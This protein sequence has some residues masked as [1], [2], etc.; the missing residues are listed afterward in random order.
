MT[1]FPRFNLTPGQI[2]LI[3]DAE[4]KVDERRGTTIWFKECF[5]SGVKGYTDAELARLFHKGTIVIKPEA[6]QTMTANEALN[7]QLMAVDALEPKFQEGLKRKH[8]Y[9]LAGLGAEGG[10][11]ASLAAI[12]RATAH[13]LGDS[14]PPRPGTVRVWKR[15]LVR[16]GMDPRALLGARAY[17]N[18]RQR[19]LHHLVHR[20]MRKVIGRFYLSRNRLSIEAV[21]GIL[22]R[23]MENLRKRYPELDFTMPSIATLAREIRRI[24]PYIVK[25]AREGTRAADRQF[26]IKKLG[27]RATRPLELVIIDSKIMDIFWTDREGRV[28]ERLTLTVV[29]DV[30]SRMILGFYLGPGKPS[31]LTNMQAMRN[32]FAP[33]DYVGHL[34]PEI[35]TE[36]PCYG[37]PDALSLDQGTEN[38]NTHLPFVLGTFGIDT[39]FGPGGKPENRGIIEAW[40]DT[41]NALIHNIA[42]TTRSNPKDRGDADRERETAVEEAREAGITLEDLRALVHRWILDVYHNREHAELRMS[43]LQKWTEGVSKHALRPPPPEEQ[44][45]ILLGKTKVCRLQHY[46]I[47]LFGLIY[48]A[49]ELA[50]LR[51]RKGASRTVTV[52]WDPSNISCIW[53]KD[54]ATHRWIKA[55]ADDQIY[56]RNLSEAQHKMAWRAARAKYAK[57]R[58]SEDELRAI[59]AEIIETYLKARPRKNKI[60]RGTPMDAHPNMPFGT[61]ADASTDGTPA[62]PRPL[63]EPDGLLNG[64]ETSWDDDITAA[65]LADLRRANGDLPEARTPEAKELGE[66]FDPDEDEDLGLEEEGAPGA[67]AGKVRSTKRRDRKQA[68]KARDS[69]PHGE[70]PTRQDQGTA[71]TRPSAENSPPSTQAR[72]QDVDEATIAARAAAMRTHHT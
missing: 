13:T 58:P 11:G 12:I 49:D 31:W 18:P 8:A 59:L 42:G 19:R 24:N 3:N 45:A 20:L 9:A 34:Y 37:L 7:R 21:H 35:R 54:E 26:R 40:N 16:N 23:R 52:K 68:S 69:R 29:I 62:Q 46:G 53:V 2:F 70:R 6:A 50:R 63:F 61:R 60:L 30:F 44:L 15:T 14:H 38:N 72:L 1:A 56:T 27:P 57:D 28:R 47:N 36:W 39:Q 5:G 10:K 67:L 22:K 4:W 17:R 32:A 55:L 33:K 64:G 51:P 71:D 41:I 25:A 43:P 66:L 48:R 65:K